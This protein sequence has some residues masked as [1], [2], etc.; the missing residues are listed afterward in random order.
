MK[1]DDRIPDDMGNGT[2]TNHASIK[3][4]WEKLISFFDAYHY[5]LRHNAG[6]GAVFFEVIRILIP[7]YAERNKRLCDSIYTWAYQSFVTGYNKIHA[8]N[9]NVPPFVRGSMIAPLFGDSGDER[10]CMYGR[11]NDYGSFRV[12]KELDNCPFSIQG[13]EVCRASAYMTEALGDTFCLNGPE[14]GEHKMKYIMS[15]ARGTGDLHCRFVIE[16]RDKYP[17]GA[18]DGWDC[19]EPCA[20]LDQIQVTPE[21]KMVSEPQQFRGECDYAYR[22]GFNMEAEAA[23]Q[24]RGGATSFILGAN[25]ILLVLDDMLKN[26][27]VTREHLENVIQCCFEGAGKMMFVEFFAV[28][29]LRDWLGVPAD[30]NDGRVLGA[31]IELLL[32]VWTAEYTVLAFNKHEVVYD[33]TKLGGSEH[34]HPLCA[35]AIISMWYGMG[36]T[37][38]GQQWVCERI[39]EG[40]D[41]DVMRVRISKKVDKFAR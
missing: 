14:S 24:F 1:I 38:V 13:S 39:S 27:E 30:V 36:R 3:T 33:I 19:F 29:G 7:D 20:T 35:H 8:S 6:L 41:D 34:R 11:V 12:E 10:L 15:E 18:R 32:Q 5:G 9:H 40:V 22:N 16:S 23:G 25:Y 37:L 17:A 2:L 4:P 26:G 28:K 21:E 31:Y